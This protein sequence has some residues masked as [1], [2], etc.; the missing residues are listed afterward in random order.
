MAVMI[1]WLTIMTITIDGTVLI[2]KMVLLKEGIS[3]DAI[4]SVVAIVH[5]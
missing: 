1:D 3:Q 2:N 5:Y 4:D